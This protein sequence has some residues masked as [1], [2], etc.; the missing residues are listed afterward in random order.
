MVLGWKKI[1][2]ARIYN[3]HMR[4]FWGERQEKGKLPHVHQR[5]KNEKGRNLYNEYKWRLSLLCVWR[6]KNSEKWLKVS[7]RTFLIS[8]RECSKLFKMNSSNSLSPPSHVFCFF[9]VNI[10]TTAIYFI[11]IFREKLLNYKQTEPER[12]CEDCLNL[13]FFINCFATTFVKLS[14]TFWKFL[15]Y[16]EKLWP[17]IRDFCGFL[18]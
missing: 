18:V 12:I 6:R 7:A 13:A 4:S 11:R 8:A 9:L 10:F 16:L 14:K 15:N 5:N 17:E 3:A 1:N 2:K